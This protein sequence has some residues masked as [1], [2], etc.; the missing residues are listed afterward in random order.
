MLKKKK[1]KRESILSLSTKELTSCGKLI[2]PVLSNDSTV[3]NYEY[4]TK[5]LN[6][7][8]YFHVFSSSISSKWVFKYNMLLLRKLSIIL[9]KGMQFG[10]EPAFFRHSWKKSLKVQSILARDNIWHVHFPVSQFMVFKRRKEK[11]YWNKSF[12]PQ[13]RGGY[14]GEV[15]LGVAQSWICQ[16]LCRFDC[17]CLDSVFPASV[18][19]PMHSKMNWRQVMALG[20]APPTNSLALEIE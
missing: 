13:G 11:G 1:K 20:L 19:V 9:Q 6:F 14:F 10:Y 3:F 12:Q 2:A 16:I 18:S 15:S 4:S 17:D 8:Q 5:C 7:L